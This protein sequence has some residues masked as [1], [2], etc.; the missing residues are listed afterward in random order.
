MP[1]NRIQKLIFMTVTVFLS[2]HVFVN[3]NMALAM[4]GMSNKVFQL[5]ERR[6]P[7]EFLIALALQLAGVN[8][9]AT[10]YALRIFDPRRDKPILF[11]L[12]LSCFT[13]MMMCPVMT[14]LL[15][16]LYNGFTP[17]FFA[18]WLQKIFNN[19]HIAF[20]SQVFLIGPLMRAA[21]RR[22]FGEARPAVVLQRQAAD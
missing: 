19:I 4:G 13:V 16:M 3:Y 2:I 6:V 20:F 7:L 5:A 22:V 21:G 14:L 18:Q 15:T 11:P 10:R 17:E 12:A 1:H 9:L 8:R